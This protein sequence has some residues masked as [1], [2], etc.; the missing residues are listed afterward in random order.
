MIKETDNK[1]EKDGVISDLVTLKLGLGQI[2]V[3]FSNGE[4]SVKN[5]P[6]REKELTCLIDNLPKSSKDKT[7]ALQEVIKAQEV[8]DQAQGVAK[9]TVQTMFPALR[10]QHKQLCERFKLLLHP[11]DHDSLDY[12]IYL[13][14]TGRCDSMK[15]ALQLLDEEKRNNRLIASLNS[16]TEYLSRNFSEIIGGLGDKLSSAISSY[17][18]TV[19]STINLQSSLTRGAMKDHARESWLSSRDIVEGLNR[20]RGDY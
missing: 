13:F 20:L 16:A 3:A 18:A 6:L 9:F 7:Q 10:Q 11:S 19:S 4:K 8:L 17:S 2:S 15:E 5:E 14:I 12:I 1:A